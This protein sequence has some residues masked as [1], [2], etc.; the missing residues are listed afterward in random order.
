MSSS[1]RFA[2]YPGAKEA[3]VEALAYKHEDAHNPVMRGY[4]VAIAASL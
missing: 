2:N 1:H 3:P 4:S